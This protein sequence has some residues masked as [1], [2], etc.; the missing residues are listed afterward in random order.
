M[1]TFIERVK[2]QNTHWKRG[3]LN[4]STPKCIYSNYVHRFGL[5]S[6]GYCFYIHL[7]TRLKMK[8]VIDF[9]QFTV[10][11]TIDGGHI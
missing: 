4:L 10:M 3:G 11:I 9:L 7:E 6:Y 1:S 8:I 2:N 5:V